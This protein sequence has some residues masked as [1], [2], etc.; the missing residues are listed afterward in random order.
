MS[1]MHVGKKSSLQPIIHSPS[2]RRHL[3]VTFQYM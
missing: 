1:V 3:L 2:S